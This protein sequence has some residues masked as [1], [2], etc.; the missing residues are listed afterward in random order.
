MSF[1]KN[2]SHQMTLND[3]YFGLTEREKKALEKLTEAAKL[4]AEM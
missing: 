3:S 2:E 4:R 1:R